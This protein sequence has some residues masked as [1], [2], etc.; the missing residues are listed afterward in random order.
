VFSVI[1]TGSKGIEP[2]HQTL[3]PNDW[4]IDLSYTRHVGNEFEV[5]RRNKTFTWNTPKCSN[6]AFMIWH[7]YISVYSFCIKLI[8]KRYIVVAIKRWIYLSIISLYFIVLFYKRL[9]FWTQKFQ[10][11]MFDFNF[12]NHCFFICT[13]IC[14]Y[15]NIHIKNKI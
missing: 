14:L 7:M 10:I 2:Y 1:S 9:I 8:E 6:I 15:T 3:D 5:N 11:L 12:F 4:T 13:C